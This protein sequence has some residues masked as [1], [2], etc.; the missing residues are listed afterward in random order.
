[1]ATAAEM[2]CPS[3]AVGQKVPHSAEAPLVPAAERAHSSAEAAVQVS[4]SAQP[5]PLAQRAAALPPGEPV[6]SAEGAVVP[7]SAAG[8]VAGALQPA[9]E[10][11]ESV[12]AEVPL[13]VAEVRAAAAGVRRPEAAAQA[14]AAVEV[15]G[16]RLT[17]AA[18]DVVVQLPAVQR[19]AALPSAAAWAFRRD[20]PLPWPAPQPAALFAP[21][22]LFA[23]AKQRRRIALP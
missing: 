10:A 7:R 17:A 23:R 5:A 14:W 18:P 12:A 20:Q 3:V 6:A 13:R 22:K 19:R 8:H 9:A 1:L 16:V 11:E 15:A 2:A 21:A 4:G